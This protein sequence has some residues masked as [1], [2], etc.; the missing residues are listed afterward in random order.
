[1]KRAVRFRSRR[2]RLTVAHLVR[3]MRRWSQ[4][5]CKAFCAFAR[6]LTMNWP[7]LLFNRQRDLRTDERKR[8]LGA[9]RSK[10]ERCFLRIAHIC[11]PNRNF[12]QRLRPANGKTPSAEG[13]AGPP[14]PPMPHAIARDE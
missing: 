2:T 7:L 6:S 12:Q 4:T 1:M 10:Q 5:T 8:L 13:L 9:S 11:V 3:L 14:V